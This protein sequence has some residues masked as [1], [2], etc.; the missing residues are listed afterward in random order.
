MR[1]SFLPA[2]TFVALSSLSL[3]A[4]AQE[5]ASNPADS[6]FRGTD[7]AAPP[8]SAPP[9]VVQVPAA[10][11]S[12]PPVVI[13]IVPGA[14]APV[15]EQPAP[16]RA[17]A[18]APQPRVVAVPKPAQPQV[19]TPVRTTKAGQRN[20]GFDLHLQYLSF[21]GRLGRNSS[22]TAGLMGAGASIRFLRGN[23][24]EWQVGNEFLTGRDFAG[25]DRSE[26]GFSVLAVRHFNPTRP[27]RFYGIGGVNAWFGDV[28]STQQSPLTPAYDKKN[29]A[30][31]AT[32]GAL[33]LQAGVGAELRLGRSFSIHADLL[34]FVRWRFAATNDAH[35]NLCQ[36]TG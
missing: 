3:S 31:Y 28:R 34:G 19:V 9:V 14:E 25:F 30:Y 8:A 26:V 22:S 33:G 16:A 1:R 6:W 13:I 32:Y 24:R 35:D 15:V 36:H 7:D 10:T 20:A 23:E 21:H 17:P 2:V 12:P 5:S 29:D 11:A 4:L 18:P 27:L